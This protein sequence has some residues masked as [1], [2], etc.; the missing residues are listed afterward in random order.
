MLTFLYSQLKT[1]VSIPNMQFPKAEPTF[2]YLNL[3]TQKF[4]T[5]FLNL[6]VDLRYASSHFIN[7]SAMT[8]P[9]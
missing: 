5:D 1:S 3:C 8:H 2:I 6:Y 4:Y 7:W 9:D